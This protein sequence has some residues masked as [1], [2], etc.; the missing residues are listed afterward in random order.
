MTEQAPAPQPAPELPVGY[1]VYKGK[2][3][4]IEGKLI[5]TYVETDANGDTLPIENP[6]WTAKKFPFAK[7][8]HIGGIYKVSYSKMDKSKYYIELDVQRYQGFASQSDWKEWDLEHK[9]ALAQDAKRIAMN[10]DL[11][12]DALAGMTLGELQARMRTTTASQR[13]A[14]LSIVIQ[15]IQN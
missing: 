12:R 11:K 15:Y 8:P 10:K 5:D 9:A 13:Q 6:H 4:T 2:R 7:R 3:L 14:I 1:F